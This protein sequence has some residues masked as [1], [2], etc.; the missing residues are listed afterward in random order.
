MRNKII[1]SFLI[2]FLFSFVIGFGIL[3]GVIY[4]VFLEKQK[5]IQ[6][7]E[8]H[9]IQ[10][11]IEKDY[12]RV[13]QF[14]SDVDSRLTVISTDGKVIFDNQKPN[15][16]ENHLKRD[17][18]Q[19]AIQNGTDSV[20]RYSKTLG[21]E[22][23]YTA[24]YDKDSNIILRLATPFK[25]VGESAMV[26]LPAFFISFLVALTIVFVLSRK[27]TKS[28]IRPLDDISNTIRHTKIGNEPIVF[29]QYTYPELKSIT[30]SLVSMNNQITLYLDQ[31]E[32]E[33]IVRQ[34]FFTNASH[35]LKTPL[36]SIRGYSELL[37]S[38]TIRDEEQVNRC[39][40]SILKESDHMTR[41]I[42]DILTISKLETET[43][44]CPMMHVNMQKMANHIVD[45]MQVQAEKMD[46]VLQIHSPLII[47][48]ANQSHMEAILYNLISN[49]IKYNRVGGTVNVVLEQNEEWLNLTV[50]DTGVGISK[51]DQERIFQRF[52]RVDRQRSKKIPGTG[53]G[54]SIVKHIVSFYKG[55]I[56]VV[57]EENQGTRITLRLPVAVK[58]VPSSETIL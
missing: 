23:L 12:D 19:G 36:T 57:S 22:L 58:E 40:D 7:D 46:I 11:I 41:L 15:L 29:D 56:D 14:L 27:M 48:Y 51:E 54:L 18:V 45:T 17:E 13:N 4:Q 43:E 44:S 52:Y 50:S 32:K 31:L 37:R 1:R 49:A 42:N 3:Y 47:V 6:Y 8:I 55:K 39:L 10:T 53:L 35:E 33:K 30:S 25:G 16:K 20:I 9:L 34:E 5:D 28:I 2:T 21:Y 38:H 24:V 26:L